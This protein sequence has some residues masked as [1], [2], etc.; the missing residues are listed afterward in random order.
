MPPG[1]MSYLASA[2]VAVGG[3]ARRGRRD[4]EAVEA[5]ERGPD[6]L[7]ALGGVLRGAH[8]ALVG[9]RVQHVTAVPAHVLEHDVRKPGGATR[10]P[11]RDERF[12]DA[13]IGDGL[14][15]RCDPPAAAMPGSARLRHVASW[16]SSISRLISSPTSRKNTAIR[17]SFIQWETLS[18]PT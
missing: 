4:V 12:E 13:A 6:E 14:L 1:E 16:P 8:G 15:R 18:G 11:R 10:I 17:A 3:R 2:P 9:P 7:F 5:A